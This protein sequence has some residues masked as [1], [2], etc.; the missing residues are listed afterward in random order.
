MKVLL[1]GGS[2]FLGKQ[3]CRSLVKRNHEV[4]LLDL[5]EP[6]HSLEKDLGISY[7]R[8]NVT[9]LEDVSACLEKHGRVEGVI[10][11]A[12]KILGDQDDPYGTFSVNV[13]GL[14]SV[15][16]A[17]RRADVTRV[18]SISTAGI[19]GRRDSLEPLNEDLPMNPQDTYEHTKAIGEGLAR[20]YA[21]RY[22]LDVRVVRFPFLYGPEQ[23]VVWPLNILLY[24]AL[25]GARLRLKQGGDY[26][27]EYLYVKDAAAGAIAALE[28]DTAVSR[29]YNI[30]TGRC[31]TV[32]E[33][34]DPIKRVFPS[35]DCDAGG[36]LWV[37][38]M[39]NDWV[40][41]PMTVKRAQEELGFVAG[42]DIEKGI[43][44]LSDWERNHPEEYGNWPK[45]E[46]WLMS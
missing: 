20:M 25:R 10:N 28:S 8:G 23:Y 2:G 34:I 9:S 37:S 29:V 15:L 27:L 11:A 32:R 14:A 42:Y 40:R 17:S 35:F 7:F 30:G 36:G 46:L 4:V 5:R 21:E 43:R 18:V 13:G 31:T 22:S 38:A 1:T 16:E 33:L 3:L 24:H 26:G 39:M 19:Y 44:D 41:G 12:A 45:N 6:A